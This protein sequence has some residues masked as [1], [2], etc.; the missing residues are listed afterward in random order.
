MRIGLIAP[1][2]LPV[3]PRGYGGTEAVVDNLARGLTDLGHDIRLFSVGESTC[4]VA[5]CHLYDRAMA[6]MGNSELEAAHVVAAYE[7]LADVDIIHDHTTIGPLIGPRPT[8]PPVVTTSHGIFDAVRRRTYARIA[9]QAA[10]IAISHAQKRSAAPIP[11]SAVIHHG[12][13]LDAYQTGPGGGGYV[14][15][16]GRMCEDKG[17]H[18]AVR[19][20]RQA[21]RKLLIVTTIREPEER[22]YYEE[23]VQPLLGPDDPEPREEPLRRRIE[24]LGAADALLN[25]IGWPEPFGLVM[26]EA[27]A[28]G[29]PVLAFPNGAAPEIIEHGKTGFLCADEYDMIAALEQL[30][31]IDR[32]NCRLAAE[33]RFSLQRMAREHA[34]LYRRILE[35]STRH[36]LTRIRA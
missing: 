31:L 12:I 21:G 19:I 20:A 16:I 13:D 17:V 32:A 1:P 4:P 24:L 9:E 25:P 6:P 27:L 2:W 5:R 26:A 15:F 28:C 11:I 7:E 35:P 36:T 33:Q 3:P 34:A 14:L 18:R 29:T 30:P 10:I 22:R 23:R 8:G